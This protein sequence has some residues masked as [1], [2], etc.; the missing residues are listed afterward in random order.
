MC[1]SFYLALGA[2]LAIGMRQD[3]K[4]LIT[5]RPMSLSAESQSMQVSVPGGRVVMAALSRGGSPEVTQMVRGCPQTGRRGP[6]EYPVHKGEAGSGIFCLSA[7]CSPLPA[8][9]EGLVGKA[10]EL[11]AQGPRAQQPTLAHEGDQLPSCPCSPLP[12]VPAK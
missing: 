12:P 4:E 10:S 11:W 1:W 9:G 3:P 8:S 7:A 2:E 6:P 5:V